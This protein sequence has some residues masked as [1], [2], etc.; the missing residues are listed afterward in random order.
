M[1]VDKPAGMTSHDVVD[2]CRRAFGQRRV[3]HAGTLDPDATGVLLVGLGQ[4]TRLLRYLTELPKTYQCELVLGVETTTLDAAGE[5]TAVHDM[6]TVGIE[7]VRVAA[8]TFVGPIN[9]IPPM[10][11]AVKIGGRRLHQ[12]AR[13]G[14]EVER[15]ARP[16]VVHYLEIDLPVLDTVEPG[17]FAM[18]VECSSGTYVR[19]LA[20]DIGA[21]LGG[22]AHLRRL[23]REAIGVFGTDRAHGLDALESGIVIPPI[24]AVAHLSRLESPDA[25]LARIANG[26]VLDL[27]ELGLSAGIAGDP[28]GPWAVVDGGGRL[29]AVYEYR[30]IDSRLKPTVVLASRAVP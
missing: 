16:V 7:Q 23:R 30:S 14:I 11:S 19:T 27:A 15:A 2:R 28:V 12:L 21:A 25:L 17:I 26:A 13:E 29:V 4:C 6:A 10:V 5:V 3:G 20:A 8:Q 9:Q 24:D 1:V 18:R 22:G